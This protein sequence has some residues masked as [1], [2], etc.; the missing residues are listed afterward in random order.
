[1]RYVVVSVT[2]GEAGDFNNNLRKDV[3][4]KFK[5]K[6]SK[7]SAHFTIKSPFETDNISE[8]DNLLYKFC[9]DNISTTYRINGYDHF[10][11]RVIYMKVIMSLEGSIVH[12]KLVDCMSKIDYINF[13]RLDGKDKI[14]HV[15]ISSKKIRPIFNELWEYVNKFR[16]D[17]ICDF[18]NICIYKWEDNTWV[19]HNEYT[20][21]KA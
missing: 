13:D 3:Y 15:T 11:D 9:K 17:F 1:M 7:L 2:K 16:C 14:F 10:D 20:L 21:K 8:L 12:D 5:T 6:S 18:D 4:N 19:L